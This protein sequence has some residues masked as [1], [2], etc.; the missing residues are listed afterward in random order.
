M[1]TVRREQDATAR[2]TRGAQAEIARSAAAREDA[3]R[4]LEQ[5]RARLQELLAKSREIV[6]TLRA[7][8]S[9]KTTLAQKL[10]A[11]DGGLKLCVD[12]N[13]EL[14]KINGEIL[15]RLERRSGRGEPFTQIARARNE[16]L[17]DEYRYRA[18]EQRAEP[19]TPR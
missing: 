15:E 4:E 7:V 19:A 3:A 6:D 2:R 9:E 17:I 8:E 16:N 11:A 18:D 1:E 13:R 12:R 5:T 10:E 14:Y